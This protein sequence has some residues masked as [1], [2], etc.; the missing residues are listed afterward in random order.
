M[1]TVM[2]GPL[3][4]ASP[5][6]ST[7]L[8]DWVSVTNASN[9]D[10][11]GGDAE[12]TAAPVA[13]ALASR[14]D[15]RR[16][17]FLARTPD[18]TPVGAAALVRLAA[19]DPPEADAWISVRP[20]ARGAGLGTALVRT[21]EDTARRLGVRR[22]VLDQASPREDG[23]PGADF[24]RSLGY[25]EWRLLLGLR[26]RL[27]VAPEILDRFEAR[28]RESCGTAYEVLTACDDLPEGWLTDRATLAAHLSTD[29]P[30]DGIDH[31]DASWDAERVRTMWMSRLAGGGHAV[32]AVVVE[33]ATGRLVAFSDLVVQ[34][35]RPTI[36]TQ[37]D[38]FVLREHRRHHLGLAVTIAGLRELATALPDV[39]SIAAWTPADNASMLHL[40][41][42][43]GFEVVEW[44]R[45]W[46][47]EL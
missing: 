16:N 46:V 38:T 32:E 18:G 37:S 14:P 34:A 41:G 5:T 12:L 27:P 25:V 4:P 13:T 45:M 47:R 31:T 43:I 29:R 26:L 2:V 23:S 8:T 17:Y 7:D 35:S 20:D 22:L 36:A 33:R 21:L 40:G 10:L 28:A 42:S 30:A 9:R 11:F 15:Q 44:T 6:W 3:D 1:S 24:A 19:D 39:E